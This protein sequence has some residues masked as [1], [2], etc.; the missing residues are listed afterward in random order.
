MTIKFVK[1]LHCIKNTTFHNNEGSFFQEFVILKSHCARQFHHSELR[2]IVSSLNTETTIWKREEKRKRT[3]VVTLRK[4]NAHRAWEIPE[5][6]HPMRNGFFI[7]EE[8]SKTLHRKTKSF[9]QNIVSGCR[10]FLC[11]FNIELICF[12]S[13]CLIKIWVSLKPHFGL[14]NFVHT[15]KF[16]PPNRDMRIL[17]FA[18]E[19]L[20]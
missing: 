3:K 17:V 8:V 4:V 14:T 15:I 1:D 18:F 2:N 16:I 5:S 9:S 6:S 12:I 13:Y 11:S 10:R 20:H 19:N 7:C